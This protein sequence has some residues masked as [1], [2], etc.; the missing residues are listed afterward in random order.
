MRKSEYVCS[1]EHSS[2]ERMAETG[3][4]LRVGL[5]NLSSAYIL[6]LLQMFATPCFSSWF[7]ISFHFLTDRS[8]GADSSLVEYIRLRL[9]TSIYFF[10]LT[11]WE[12]QGSYISDLA[13]TLWP[14]LILPFLSNFV[15]HFK[16]CLVLAHFPVCMCGKKQRDEWDHD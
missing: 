14:H 12:Q 6:P 5:A 16:L 2:P 8:I 7:S 15:L 9:S 10:S 11:N 3:N 1:L 13:Q 4:E